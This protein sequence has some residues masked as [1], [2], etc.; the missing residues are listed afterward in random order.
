MS[1]SDPNPSNPFSLNGEVAVVTGGGTGLGRG[2]ASCLHQAG[3]SVLV[4]GRREEPLAETV[5]ALGDRRTAHLVA[6]ITTAGAADAVVAAA[7]ERFGRPTIL[8]NNAGIHLKKPAL[9][10][11]DDEFRAVLDTHVTASFSLARAA[12]PGMAENG[13]GSILFVSSMTAYMG[14][15]LVVAYSAAKSA[16]K[17]MV[18]TLSGEWAP[19][20]IRVN[21]VAPGWID[22][23]MLR[24][25]IE[26]DPER[27][28]RIVSRI[29]MD[30]FGSPEDVGW[31][32]V[33]LSSPAARYVTGLVMPVDGGGHIG[34]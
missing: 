9:E 24:R 32:A 13:R 30:H 17:G 16:V 11:A 5:A 8:V 33:Y 3:A 19:R 12:A 22:T 18:Y 10:T 26:A 29:Q 25:A 1:D 20:G 34:F 21:A 15:P 28:R 31:A 7:T 23:P 27:K 2:I 4:V 6:D 14:M